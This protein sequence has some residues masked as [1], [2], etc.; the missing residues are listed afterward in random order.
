MEVSVLD[1]RLQGLTLDMDPFLACQSL[2][3]SP[4]F[5]FHLAGT[6]LYY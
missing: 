3:V 5:F 1:E 6:K 4:F 2:L